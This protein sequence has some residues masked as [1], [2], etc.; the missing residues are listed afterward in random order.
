[1]SRKRP[2]LSACLIVK[3]EEDLLPAC[4][5]SLGGLAGEIIVVDT[6]S[7]DR[8]IE[9][10]ESYGAR[11]DRQ[12]WSGDFAAARNRSLELA[13]GE[14]IL[15]IDADEQIH[16]EDRSAVADLLDVSRADAYFVRI[17]SEVG[18]EPAAGRLVD[19]RLSLFR[20]LTGLA[21]RGAIHEEILSSMT[22]V[23]GRP[24]LVPAPLRL[25]HRGY[26]DGRLRSK[27]KTTR[28]LEIIDKKVK[29]E[30]DNPF[31]HYAAAG[32][33]MATEQYREALRHLG[34]CLCRWAPSVS[35]H[36]DAVK[37]TALCQRELGLY[38]A[39]RKTLLAGL[40]QHPRMTDLA[41]L[42]GAVAA[43]M[44]SN[45]EA[46]AFFAKCL[47]MGEAPPGYASWEG[48]GSYRARLALAGLELGERRFEAAVDHCLAALRDNPSFQPALR[49]VIGAVSAAPDGL[50]ILEGRFDLEDGPTLVA[51]SAAASQSG[52]PGM[53][54]RLL[55][56][57]I[58][59]SPGSPE[60]FGLIV[61]LL[62]LQA[63]RFKIQ[64]ELDTNS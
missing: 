33:L 24:R 14:W 1:M 50:A 54:A 63:N 21:F 42:L 49:L 20:N 11:V 25:I 37:K 59:R 64:F 5:D 15:I 36:G 29:A 30:P 58:S 28:N 12:E 45:G 19:H 2:L 16:P 23:L 18:P 13:T 40:A 4:L 27:N 51:L 44:G 56:R 61:R 8:T 26:T 10:A 53:A 57:A 43:A 3:D 47:E 32:E 7:A 41:Y 62:E 6:G 9:I 55:R 60:I 38:R 34:V 46:A 52:R 17:E 31:W 48:T 35:F 39:A 22:G